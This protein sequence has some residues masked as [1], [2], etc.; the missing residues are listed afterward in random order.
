MTTDESSRRWIEFMGHPIPEILRAWARRAS[1]EYP[2]ELQRHLTLCNH[3]KKQIAL[4]GTARF[5]SQP[6]LDDHPDPTFLSERSQRTVLEELVARADVIAPKLQE[7]LGRANSLTSVARALESNLTPL[8]KN[9]RM[10]LYVCDPTADEGKGKYYGL[11]SFGCGDEFRR[12]F[13]SKSVLDAIKS[14]RYEIERGPVPY[15]Y[16]PAGLWYVSLLRWA[17]VARAYEVNGDRPMPEELRQRGVPNWVLD[18][19]LNQNGDRLVDETL[20]IEILTGNDFDLQSRNVGDCVGAISIDLGQIGIHFPYELARILVSS[21]RNPLRKWV[22]PEVIRALGR[23]GTSRVKVAKSV[24]ALWDK[25]EFQLAVRHGEIVLNVSGSAYPEGNPLDEV[26]NELPKYARMSESVLIEGETGVGKELIAEA[27]CQLRDPPSKPYRLNC[28]QFSKETIASELFG[29]E[30]G[31]FTG[32]LERKIGLLELAKGGVVFLNQIE[33]IPYQ[34]Q[35]Q[36]KHALEERGSQSIM[37]VGGTEPIRVDFWL[38][39]G[40][41]GK[42]VLDDEG[43][44]SAWQQDRRQSEKRI[45]N[46]FY[47]RIANNLLAVPSLRER[48]Y[49]VP[50]LIAYEL[51]RRSEEEGISLVRELS[52]VVLNGECVNMLMAY[53]WPGNVRELVRLFVNCIL[54]IALGKKGI[55]TSKDLKRKLPHIPFDAQGQWVED[56]SWF[57]IYPL[58]EKWASLLRSSRSESRQGKSGSS[59]KAVFKEAEN[60]LELYYALKTRKM[61][62]LSVFPPPDDLEERQE[63]IRREL[64]MSILKYAASEERVRSL[65]DFCKL[66][67]I[68]PKEKVGK[69]LYERLKQYNINVKEVFRS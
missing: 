43:N 6:V 46:D 15:A 20:T 36:L 8:S 57:R 51:W 54:I 23:E 48:R 69:R 18:I 60:L 58:E 31:S 55:V 4:V 66:L 28:G 39:T 14:M 22:E 56:D 61:E 49:D 2:E 21:L 7:E 16:E 10:R 62:I 63:P 24:M 53:G 65:A 19:F 5:A 13:D 45:Q 44:F 11:W 33:S 47:H 64:L 34:V 12:R 42:L 29:H 35:D 30:R 68:D 50:I 41:T 38:I 37:R 25:D 9:L 40:C 32:A 17:E 52:E 26:L 27:L 59:G 67:Q 1:A 3:C